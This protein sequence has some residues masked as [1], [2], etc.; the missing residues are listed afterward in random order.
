[1]S[2][3]EKWRDGF[4]DKEALTASSIAGLMKSAWGAAYKQAIDDAVEVALSSCSAEAAFVA[5]EIESLKSNLE[6]KG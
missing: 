4:L 2:D 3:F 6:S 5:N 1:M